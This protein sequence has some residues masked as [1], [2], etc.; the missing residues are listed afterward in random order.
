MSFE[1][2]KLNDQ[3]LGDF[4]EFI[5]RKYA[6]SKNFEAHQTNVAETDVELIWLVH[7]DAVEGKDYDIEKM[8][9][10]WDQTTIAD[11]TIIENN[12]KGVLSNHYAPGQLSQMEVAVNS[13]KNWYLKHTENNL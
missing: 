4:G 5:Y 10:M 11:K 7:K 12:Q 6:E 1:K 9:W 3:L 2:F 8:V 13:F